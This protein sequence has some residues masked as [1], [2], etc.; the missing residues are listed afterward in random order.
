MFTNSTDREVRDKLT[1]IYIMAR[2][3][4]PLSYQQLTE[5][6]M[7]LEL[8]NYFTMLQ[9]ITEMKDTGLIEENHVEDEELVM[10]TKDGHKTLSMFSERIS[11]STAEMIEAAIEV[12][13]SKMAKERQ[14]KATYMRINDNEFNVHLE[15]LEGDNHLMNLK[16]LV[17]SQ[18]RAKMLCESWKRNAPNLYGDLIHQIVKE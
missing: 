9:Y 17:F 6:V 3:N 10:V 11:A 7:G 2:F 18:E 15:M 16:F 4:V 14:I 13:K 8:M 12:T 5:F 1:L